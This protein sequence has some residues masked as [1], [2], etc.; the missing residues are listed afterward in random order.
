MLTNEN[1]IGIFQEYLKQDQEIEIVNTSRGYLKIEWDAN[2]PYYNEVYL[3]TTPE[4]LF[5]Q[6]LDDFRTYQELALTKGKREATIEEDT[7]VEQ[8]CQPYY[9]KRKELEE[10]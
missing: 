3:C 9:E 5:E 4:E 2:S 8:L 10:L 1:V 7:L 6:L